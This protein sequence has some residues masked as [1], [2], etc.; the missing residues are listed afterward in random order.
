M[1]KGVEM[2]RWLSTGRVLAVVAALAAASFVV[3]STTA[4]RTTARR[5][6]SGVNGRT[7]RP[8]SVNGVLAAAR[9][10]VIDHKSEN[11]QG[12]ITRRTAANYPVI[13]VTELSAVPRLPGAESLKRLASARCGS[14]TAQFAWAVIFTDTQSVLCCIREI[15]FVVHVKNGWKVF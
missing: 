2:A 10:V 13:E 8:V 15:V 6:P 14:E 11:N 5:C 7:V 4:A 9:R 1:R 3:E 12:R